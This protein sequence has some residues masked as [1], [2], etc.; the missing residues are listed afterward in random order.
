MDTG[1]APVLLTAGRDPDDRPPAPGQL[2]L[3]QALVNTLSGHTQADLIAAP[4]DAA[5]WLT[6]AG[7]LPAGSAVTGSEQRAL[8]EL[9]E[10]IRAVL[11]SHAHSPGE[12]G[13]ADRLT[14][15]LLPCRLIVTADPAG[16][17]RLSSADQHPFARA[18]GTVA[19]AIAESAANGTWT[20]LK[21]CPGH[22]C[23]WAFY[24]RSPAARSQW[25][26]MQLCGAR[27]KMRAYRG[28]QA[29]RGLS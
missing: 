19:I 7:L 29:R 11:E 5:N 25:C 23:G 4:Q 26:S 12:P 28:R 2:R 3:I 15:A 18:V 24:D 17:M 20:R 6:A 13:A 8:T 21:S 9:R 16:D 22:R 27:A 1:N 14:M 10:S